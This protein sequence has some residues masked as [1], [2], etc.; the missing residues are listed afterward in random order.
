[1]PTSNLH[2]I[3]DIV[4]LIVAADPH[5]ILDVGV[6]FGKFGVLAREYLEL[7]DGRAVYGDWQRR[8]D[9][10]EV[11]PGYLTGLHET[12]Y[13]RVIVGDAAEILP[14][15]PEQH[16]DLVL[17][18]DIIEHFDRPTGREILRQ[19][20]RVGRNVVV[21]TP[22]EFFTQEGY[23]NPHEQHLSLWSRRDLRSMGQ[24]C[25]FLPETHALLGFLGRDTPRVRARVLRLRRRLKRSIAILISPLRF[26]RRLLSP[27]PRVE[28]PP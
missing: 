4:E 24:P 13:D 5:S 22:L 15:L 6:G 9:G 16:Y 18:V 3:S 28:G 27:A 12:I 10:I 7:L 26:I 17:L 8:I 11:F 20:L 2:Q 19:C 25:F 23:D 1:M 14:G 21:G